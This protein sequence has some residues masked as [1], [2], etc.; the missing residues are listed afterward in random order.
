MIKTLFNQQ[1]TNEIIIRI[2]KLVPDDKCKWG[3]MTPTA[4]LYHCNKTNTAI[5][6]SKPTDKTPTLKQRLQKFV[7]MNVLQ[8]LPK[9]RK[10]RPKFLQTQDQQLGFKEE[11]KLFIETVS[12]FINYKGNLNGAHP[13]FG[14]LN[15]MEWGHFAWMHMYHHLRQFGV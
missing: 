8:R 15:T 7:V 11:R 12:G 1:N 4:M 6:E 10:S 9:G 14:R 5:M 2:N 3:S 13:N